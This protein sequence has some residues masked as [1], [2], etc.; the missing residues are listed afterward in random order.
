MRTHDMQLGRLPLYRLSYARFKLFPDP[1]TPKKVEQKP[2]PRPLLCHLAREDCE[3]F[4]PSPAAETCSRRAAAKAQDD[5]RYRNLMV[6]AGG[7][8]PP[9]SCSQGTRAN[10][11]APRPERRLGRIG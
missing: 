7:F 3:L 8:E 5:T 9:T 4:R 6:G 10:Q 11:T 1:T 2:Q